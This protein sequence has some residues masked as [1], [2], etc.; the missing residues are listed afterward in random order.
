MSVFV[1][2]VG[3]IYYGPSN[4]Y[5]IVRHGLKTMLSL[6]VC[7]YAALTQKKSDNTNSLMIVLVAV[8]GGGGTCV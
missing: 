7:A 1:C 4:Y 3:P 8:L 6:S 5:R 2:T